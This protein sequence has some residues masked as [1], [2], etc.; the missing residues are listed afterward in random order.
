MPLNSGFNVRGTY[1]GQDIQKLKKNYSDLERG[2]KGDI[3]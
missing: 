1:T 2:C 3:E